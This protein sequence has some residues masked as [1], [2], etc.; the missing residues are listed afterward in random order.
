MRKILPCLLESVLTNF[1][2]RAALQLEV[3]AL[4][5]QLEVLQRT[6]AARVRLDSRD[7]TEFFGY[8]CIAWRSPGDYGSAYHRRSSHGQ[9]R[10]QDLAKASPIIMVTRRPETMTRAAA[11]RTRSRKR[12]RLHPKRR[13]PHLLQRQPLYTVRSFF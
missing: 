6:R 1:R 4:R 5:H 3:I 10:C 12:R 11:R 2:S 9:S 7:W 13:G 8:Y